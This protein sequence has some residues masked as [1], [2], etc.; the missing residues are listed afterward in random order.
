MLSSTILAAAEPLSGAGWSIMLVSIGSVLTLVSFCLYKV[1]SLPPV[2]VEEHI[3]G[4]L[5]IDTGDTDE[6]D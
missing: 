6:T 1:L 5:E 3:K 4:P 2:D